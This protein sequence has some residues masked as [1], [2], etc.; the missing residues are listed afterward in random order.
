MRTSPEHVRRRAAPRAL[1][2]A[3]VG[4]LVLGLTACGDDGAE[5]TSPS[6]TAPAT[7][8]STTTTTTPPDPD[9]TTTTTGGGAAGTSPSTP[10]P[11][12]AADPLTSAQ[13]KAELVRILERYRAELQGA[14]QRNA[15]DEQ[16]QAG[17]ASVLLPA[18]RDNELDVLQR[19]GAPASL[20]ASIMPVSIGTVEVRAGDGGCTSGTARIDFTPFYGAAA[21]GPKTYF[22]KMTTDEAPGGDWRLAAVGFTESGE[23]FAAA[24]CEEQSP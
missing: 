16:L 13:A 18:L 17:L 12:G 10:S 8:A 24:E 20:A 6:T 7:S 3:L 2:L 21:A 4:L 1:A 9:G 19:I 22:F 11:G 5:E 15:L 14:K 23:P